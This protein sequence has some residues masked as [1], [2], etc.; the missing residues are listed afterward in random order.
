M[1]INDLLKDVFVVRIEPTFDHMRGVIQRRLEFAE[2]QCGVQPGSLIQV[3]DSAYQAIAEVT[4]CSPGLALEV[5]KMI[6]RSAEQRHQNH[7]YTVTEDHVRNLGLTY[8]ALCEYWDSPL[9]EATVIQ[10]KP[11]CKQE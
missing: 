4:Q 2:E 5:M 9:R 10:V 6:M 11:W 3:T 8:E 7:P 1:A